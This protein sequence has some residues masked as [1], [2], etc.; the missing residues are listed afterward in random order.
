[1]NISRNIEPVNGSPEVYCDPMLG[2]VWTVCHTVFG[3]FMLLRDLN[4]DGFFFSV[5]LNSDVLLV[6]FGYIVGILSK[7]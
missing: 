7:Y 4:L 3:Y 5:F 2:L 1:M 6:S